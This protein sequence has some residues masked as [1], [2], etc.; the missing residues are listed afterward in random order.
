MKLEDIGEDWPDM[1][2][3]PGM[4]RLNKLEGILRRLPRPP[5]G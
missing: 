1:D 5:V 2:F 4:G 3:F